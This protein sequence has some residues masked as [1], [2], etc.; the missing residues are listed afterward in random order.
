MQTTIASLVSAILAAAAVVSAAPLAQDNDLAN[1]NN[2]LEIRYNPAAVDW[3][4][5]DWSKVS[6]NKID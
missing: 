3:S 4:K 2:V 6:W 1:T 5:V